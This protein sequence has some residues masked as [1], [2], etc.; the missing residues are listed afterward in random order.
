VVEQSTASPVAVDPGLGVSWGL[1]W[2][3][4]RVTDDLHLWQW[5]NNT[6]YRAFAIASLRTGDGFVMLTNSENGLELAEPLARKILP[7]EH[8][9]FQS[10]IMG[11]DII[12]LLCNTLRVCL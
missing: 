5:G 4:E 10:S 6:G 11:T 3:L 9:L 7:G 1:G 12:N 8:R 2:G